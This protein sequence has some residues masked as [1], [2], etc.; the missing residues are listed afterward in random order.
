MHS[1]LAR[2]LEL[3]DLAASLALPRFRSLDL[4]VDTKPDLTPVTEVDRAVERALREAL[5]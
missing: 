5:D 1:D 4:R 2:A 3:A